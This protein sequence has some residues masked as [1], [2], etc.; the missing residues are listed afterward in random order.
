RQPGRGEAN[1]EGSARRRGTGPQRL[2]AALSRGQSSTTL[3]SLERRVANECPEDSIGTFRFAP[4][5]RDVENG[6]RV[7]TVSSGDRYPMA[8]SNCRGGA[9]GCAPS[10]PGGRT[11]PAS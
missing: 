1:D 5:S 7:G 6:T 3:G 9:T 10:I 2:R 8:V 11:C 4:A